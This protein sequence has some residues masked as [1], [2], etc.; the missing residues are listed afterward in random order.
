MVVDLA[1][2]N[3]GVLLDGALEFKGD[4]VDEADGGDGACVPAVAAAGLV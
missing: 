3:H 1:E 4:V 2:P